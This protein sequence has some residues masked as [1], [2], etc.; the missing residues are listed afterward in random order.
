MNK[1][2]KTD[3]PFMRRFFEE[4]RKI[5]SENNNKQNIDLEIQ[6]RLLISEEYRRADTILIYAARENEIAT[7]GIIHAAL[8][9]RKTVALPVCHKGG[10]MTFHRIDSLSQLEPGR[11]GIPEPVE[12]CPEVIPDADTLCICPALCCEMR[13]YRLGWG[14]GF[15]DRYLAKYDCLKVA[16]CYSDALIPEFE[17]DEYDIPMDIICTEKYIRR[18]SAVKG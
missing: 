3:K 16:L 17:V 7:S 13:G 15:Y 4:K 1:P 12:G 11:F 2:A 9:N 14:G 8:A 18:L 10:V 6:G 5:L